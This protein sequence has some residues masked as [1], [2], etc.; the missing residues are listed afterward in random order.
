MLIARFLAFWTQIWRPVNSPFF[1]SA[2]IHTFASDPGP[3]Q[4]PSFAIFLNVIHQ[5]S[6]ISTNLF[7]ARFLAFWRPTNSPFFSFFAPLQ[8]SWLSLVQTVRVDVEAPEAHS[9]WILPVTQRWRLWSI[10][11]Y[12]LESDHC[13]LVLQGGRMFWFA[14]FCLL[15]R[16]HGRRCCHKAGTFLS[17]SADTSCCWVWR[18]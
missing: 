6:L 15:I 18:N 17:S 3:S 7:I 8:K 9:S 12:S 1:T 13:G 14:W 5:L 16:Q 10:C 11:D 4:G 2:G